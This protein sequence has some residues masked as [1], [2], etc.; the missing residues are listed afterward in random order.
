MPTIVNTQCL[1]DPSRRIRMAW[2]Y[3]HPDHMRLANRWARGALAAAE[4]EWH[5]GDAHRIDV[6]EMSDCF[7]GD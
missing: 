3:W 4:I 5:E 7:D 6:G 2:V 1:P